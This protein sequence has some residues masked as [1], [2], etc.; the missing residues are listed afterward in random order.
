[1]ST[2]LFPVIRE[3]EHTLPY[4]LNSVAS[5]F[6]IEHIVRP[7]TSEA[8]W[9]L[10]TRSG[11]GLVVANAFEA[12]VGPGQAVWIAPG[13]THELIADT[14]GWIVDWLSISGDGLN[15]LAKEN[16]RL[17]TTSVINLP[18]AEGDKLRGLV[19]AIVATRDDLSPSATRQRSTLV[20]SFLLEIDRLSADVAAGS[21]AQREQRLMPVLNYIAQHF[22][23]TIALNTLSDL[24]EVTPQHLCTMFR[25]FMGMRIF[26]YINLIRIQSS[27]ADL[28]AYPDKPVRSVAHEC[29]FDDV[30]YF[31]SIFKRCEKMTPG[32]YRK[33]YIMSSGDGIRLVN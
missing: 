30:S 24:L 11:S 32:D 14:H 33:L 25:K 9:W 27:K 5:D 4:I 13:K 16:K 8:G 23:E 6:S 28:I 29:G 2:I 10:Q 19:E 12:A 20:Y 22:H 17:S 18:E 31:C 15:Q 1:M 3:S 26:E 21:N 7:L